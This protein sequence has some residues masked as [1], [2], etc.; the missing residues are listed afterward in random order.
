M[1]HWYKKVL[2]RDSGALSR[3]WTEQ[4]EAAAADNLDFGADED[5]VAG[6]VSKR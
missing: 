3:T 5:H 2:L 4:T 1:S 6:S